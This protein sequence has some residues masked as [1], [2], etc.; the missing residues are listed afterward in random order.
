MAYSP[1]QNQDVRYLSK[2]AAD[3]PEQLPDLPLSL[4]HGSPI[5]SDG[6]KDLNRY[7]LCK[8]RYTD[9]CMKKC[10]S[11]HSSLGISNLN[12]KILLHIY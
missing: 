4:P 7:L 1:K 8:R 2:W 11:Q 5:K 9:K 3:S 10:S 12:N 6:K